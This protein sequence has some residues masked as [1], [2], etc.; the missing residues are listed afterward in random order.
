MRPR[1]PIAVLTALAVSAAAS[2]A[3]AQT[4]HRA[5]PARKVPTVALQASDFRFCAAA[6]APCLP[7]AS[8]NTTTVKAGTR[9]VWTYQDKACD[10]VLVCP[11]HNVVFTKGGGES[12]LYKSDGATMFSMLFRRAGTYSYFCSAHQAFGMTG[13]I[14]VTK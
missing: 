11:G 12:K 2:A 8:N 4:A 3:S 6:T 7:T 10:V 5:A 13:T 14:V 9:I 1:L